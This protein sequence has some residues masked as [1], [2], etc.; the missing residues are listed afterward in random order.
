MVLGRKGFG[1]VDSNS[2]L[3]GKLQS[4]RVE[5]SW[6]RLA[7]VSFLLVQDLAI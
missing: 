3:H 6:V 4:F 5:R 2:D 1:D 7:V